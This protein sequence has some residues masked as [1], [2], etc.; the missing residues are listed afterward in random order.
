MIII[1]ERDLPALYIKVSFRTIQTVSVQVYLGS[2][3]PDGDHNFAL[4]QIELND[5]KYTTSEIIHEGLPNRIND[6]KIFERNC[7]SSQSQSQNPWIVGVM[8]DV[9]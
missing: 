7:G 5:S 4:V 3:D 2:L 8:I 9:S 1:S 6:I